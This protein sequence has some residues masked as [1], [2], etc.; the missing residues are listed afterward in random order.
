MALAQLSIDLVAKVAA[1]ER[2]LKRTADVTVAQSQRMAQAFDLV[3]S[4]IAGIAAG[5]SAGALVAFVRATVDA[6]DA[7][8]DVADATGATVENISALEDVAKRT[9][10][11]IETVSS[12]LVKFNSVLRDADPSKGPGAI[13]KALGLEVQALKREDPAEALRQVAV[14]LSGYADDG[15]K[16]RAVQELFGKSVKEAAPFLKDLAE[17]GQLNAKVTTEQAAE[18]EKFNKELFKLQTNA[19]D[20]ARAIVGSL[21]P[22]LN[23]IF[24]DVRTFGDKATLAGLAS[25]V[26]DLNRDLNILKEKRGNPFFNQEAIEKQIGEVTAKFEAAKKAFNDARGFRPAGGGRGFINPPLVRP[27]LD[28]PG[29]PGNPNSP[30]TAS[31]ATRDPTADAKRYLDSLQGQLQT[32]QALTATEKLLDDIR[33]GSL[34]KLTPDLEKQLKATAAQVDATRQLADAEKERAQNQKGLDDLVADIG[35]RDQER[36]D[37]LLGASDTGRLDKQRADM[38]FLAEAY[39]QG[40]LGAVGSEEAMRKFAESAQAYLGTGGTVPEAMDAMTQAA[41]QASERIQGA[42]G[43]ELTNLLSGEFDNIGNSFSKL[44]QRMVAEAAAAKIMDSLFGTVD[45]TTKQRSGGGLLDSASKWLS[46][47]VASANGNVFPAGPGISAYSSQVVSKPTLFPFAKGIGLM[48]EA[49]AE[50]IMPL[51]RGPDGRLGVTAAGGGGNV[52]VNVINQTGQG[53]AVGSQRESTDASGNRMLEL[54]LVAV[55]DSLANRSGAPARGLEAGYN[56]R[57]AMA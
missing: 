5:V 12:T 9:G 41:L 38:L 52:T 57:P 11:N 28:I 31:A 21:V 32:A 26:T 19:S 55:G 27:E 1:F 15:N 7:L 53:V 17:N 3:K 46:N 10:T 40:R 51:R 20:A 23:R 50:A 39:E 34:G 43:D 24:E 49:G 4:G 22:A 14:A 36:L 42:L 47:L 18:A 54:V 37:A 13:L 25:S 29:Q 30:R 6:V 44:I 35:R 56:L 45:A 8:N 2:D 48:G 33:R 16:A